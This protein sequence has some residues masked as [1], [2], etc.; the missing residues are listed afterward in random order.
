MAA[1]GAAS[2]AD[3][4]EKDVVAAGMVDEEEKAWQLPACRTRRR[5]AWLLAERTRRTRM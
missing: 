2:A 4:D 1:R 3:K 5:S